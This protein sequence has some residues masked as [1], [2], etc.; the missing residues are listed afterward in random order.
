MTFSTG[1]FKSS[2]LSEQVDD[3]RIPNFCSFFAIWMPMS[4]VAMKHVIPL[5]PLLG[6]T[7]AKIKKTSASY[8]FVIHIFEPLMIQ[9]SPSFFA[10][11][12]SENASEP[13]AGSDKQNDPSCARES[14]H[15]TA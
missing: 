2:K 3:A 8:E 13:A 7:F 4:F 6:S 10:R 9:W 14:Q 11:V 1:I 5:Y 15:P 12:C